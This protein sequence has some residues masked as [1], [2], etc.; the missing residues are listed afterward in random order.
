VLP[1][2]IFKASSNRWSP[3]IAWFRLPLLP[4]SFILRT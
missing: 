2:S 3:H 1:C 4:F